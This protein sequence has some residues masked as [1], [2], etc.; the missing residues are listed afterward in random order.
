MRMAGVLPTVGFCLAGACLAGETPRSASVA[1]LEAEVRQCME[2]LRS[3][4]YE[5]ARRCFERVTQANPRSAEAFFYLGMS[6]LLHI[7]YQPASFDAAWAN[8]AGD[9]MLLR[10]L[11]VSQG[12]Q[13]VQLML[14]GMVFGGT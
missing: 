13:S 10:Q 8:T 5:Q 6:A 3:K 7:G 1:S 12:Q 4:N 11:G 9:M 2:L 14:N